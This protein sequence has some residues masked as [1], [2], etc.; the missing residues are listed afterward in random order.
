MMAISKGL[1]HKEESN[2]NVI[3]RFVF[4]LLHKTWESIY[5]QCFVP[6]FSVGRIE[7]AVDII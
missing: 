7:E 6:Y 5:V 4:M 2:E 1:R 3:H